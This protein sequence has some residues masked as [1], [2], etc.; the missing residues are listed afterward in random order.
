ML[1]FFT[2][3]NILI[4]KIFYAGLNQKVLPDSLS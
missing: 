4:L 1:A 2:L 3:K